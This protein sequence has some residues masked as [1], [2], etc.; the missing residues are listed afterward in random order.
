MYL[1]KLKQKDAPLMLE[2][3]HDKDMTHDL[4]ANF[5]SKGLEDTKKFINLS[6]DISH[7]LHLAIVSDTDEYMGTVSLKF[8]DKKAGNAEFAII[9]RKNAAGKGYSWYGM[10]EILKIAFEKLELN[11][12]YW[13]VSEK[14]K[15]AIRFYEKHGFH[16]AL[17]ISDKILKRYDG[18]D[19][20]KWY[21][22][23][24]GDDYR[25]EG[26]TRGSI[27][28]CKI[29]SIKTIPTLDAGELSFFEGIH[30]VPFDINRIYYISKVPEGIRRGYHAHK[31]L[32]QLLFCPFGKIQLTLDDGIEKDEIILSDPSIGLL[33]D[34][35]VWR[36]MLWLQKDSV[37]C[38]AAS[39]YYDAED[40]IR[41]YKQ[42]KKYTRGYQNESN[43]YDTDKWV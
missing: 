21:S 16:E 29:I 14:N 31:K 38:V 25:N 30:D 6:K 36:E 9:V 22:V 32:K 39:D 28:G 19:D 20:L 8:I 34:R 43:H 4:A 18:I 1:R 17:D 7:S 5:A 27:A 26:I 12:V 35:P 24:K 3:M 23:L 37:L 40:Y 42:F 33:I 13:C 11:C 41:D 10:N 15:R 2:W